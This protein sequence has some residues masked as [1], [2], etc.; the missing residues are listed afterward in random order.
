MNRRISLLGIAAAL[1]SLGYSAYNLIT[2]A[3]HT[4]HTPSN[5]FLKV[6]LQNLNFTALAILIFLAA[7]LFRQFGKQVNLVPFAVFG[8]VACLV[9]VLYSG[10]VAIY[11]G[12]FHLLLILLPLLLAFFFVMVSLKTLTGIK[13]SLE[14]LMLLHF[15]HILLI[16]DTLTMVGYFNL[17]LVLSFGV[18]IIYTLMLLTFYTGLRFNQPSLADLTS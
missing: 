9:K 10:V 12:M 2:A 4:L 1:L 17:H 18:P 6:S 14:L 7:L 5:L 11:L 16:L 13:R 15:I 8:A 3:I